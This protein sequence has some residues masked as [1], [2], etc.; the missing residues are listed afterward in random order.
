[1]GN[2]IAV[3]TTE[4]KHLSNLRAPG[5]RGRASGDPL[6]ILLDL[7]MPRMDGLQVLREIRSDPGVAPSPFGDL[8][9]VASES[10]LG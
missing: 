3:A 2:E 1:V 10:R 9:L 8:V 6:L 4:S 7:R 5:L